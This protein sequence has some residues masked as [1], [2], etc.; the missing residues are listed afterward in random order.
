MSPTLRALFQI[1]LQHGALRGIEKSAQNISP[2]VIPL[3]WISAVEN[4]KNHYF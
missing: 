4:I 3:M 2:L 1:K